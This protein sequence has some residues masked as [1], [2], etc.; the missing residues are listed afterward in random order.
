[1]V[2][3]SNCAGWLIDCLFRENRLSMTGISERFSRMM[4]RNVAM[5]TLR[6]ETNMTSRE[7]RRRILWDTWN[8]S[9]LDTSTKSRLWRTLLSDV[10]TIYPRTL[11]LSVLRISSQVSTCSSERRCSSMKRIMFGSISSPSIQQ[12]C[13][14]S[15]SI[16]PL[17]SDVQSFIQKIGKISTSIPFFFFIWSFDE[18]SHACKC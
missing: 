7:Q 8:Y 18:S 6:V 11:I 14:F 12:S 4:A 13:V 1:M 9:C 2:I 17:S 5:R 3:S 10:W 15:V 16:K